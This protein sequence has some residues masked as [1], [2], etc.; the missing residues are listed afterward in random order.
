MGFVFAGTVSPASGGPEDYW[1]DVT[2][3]GSAHNPNNLF[4]IAVLK[5]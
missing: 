1:P 2:N 4:F 3:V 5:D